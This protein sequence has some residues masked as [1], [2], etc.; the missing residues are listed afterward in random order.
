MSRRPLKRERCL[1]SSVVNH[2]GVGMKPDKRL[3]AFNE[4]RGALMDEMRALDP[5]KLVAKPCR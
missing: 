2:E 1:G 5:A 4:K 3:Q